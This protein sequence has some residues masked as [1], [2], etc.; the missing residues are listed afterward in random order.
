MRSQACEEEVV[1][2]VDH[3]ADAQQP[4]WYVLFVRSNQEKRVAD[5][6]G[7]RDV[8]HFLPCYKSVRQWKDRRVTLEIPLFP[9]YVFL[10]LSLA[11]RAK[12]LTVSNVVSLVGNRN[13]PSAISDEEIAWIKLGIEHGKAEPYP[14]LK[15]GQ[16]VVVTDGILCGMEGIL[17][18]RRNNTRVVVSLDSIVRSFVVEIDASCARPLAARSGATTH[19]QAAVSEIARGCVSETRRA[20]YS[21]GA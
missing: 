9:G 13:Q 19:E 14:Y 21:V 7:G 1:F 11:E 2:V 20:V 15:L 6:L 17:V 12:A 3:H 18:Q 4:R 5:A 10:R 16:R 8:E